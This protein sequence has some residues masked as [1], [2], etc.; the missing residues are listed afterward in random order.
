[1]TP[2]QK[3]GL[4]PSMGFQMPL[5]C[6]KWLLF[7]KTIHIRNGLISSDIIR[8]GF[9]KRVSFEKCAVLRSE[10]KEPLL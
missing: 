4:A 3:E 8:E 7:I 6:Y 1:M 2:T 5:C 10:N 9:T